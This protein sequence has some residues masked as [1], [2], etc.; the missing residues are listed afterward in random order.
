MVSDIAHGRA[1]RWVIGQNEEWRGASDQQWSDA[2]VLL[3]V[4]SRSVR[5]RF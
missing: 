1:A 4:R 2:P 3:S 5:W